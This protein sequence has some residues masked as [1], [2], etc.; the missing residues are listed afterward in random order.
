MKLK[1]C[2][3]PDELLSTEKSVM[4]GGVGMEITGTGRGALPLLLDGPRSSDISQNGSTVVDT[5][6]QRI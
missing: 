1:T 6:L 5:P 2:H 4:G 3:S